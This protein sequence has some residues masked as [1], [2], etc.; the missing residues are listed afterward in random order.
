MQEIRAKK[1]LDRLALLV[2][3]RARV[4]RDGQERS[5]LVEDVV[6]GDAIRLGPGQQVV[7]DGP[8][9]EA[10]G[11][12]P[13]ESVLTGEADPVARRTGETGQTA[14]VCVAGSGFH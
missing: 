12:Q 13:D 11:L 8:L 2:A 3:P 6:A 7:A 10:R 4:L 1:Q 14:L 9:T 5:L